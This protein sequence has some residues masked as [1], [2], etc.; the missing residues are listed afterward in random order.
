[1]QNIIL[2]VRLDT[3]FIVHFYFPQK[4]NCQNTR[5]GDGAEGVGG[6]GRGAPPQKKKKKKLPMY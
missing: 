2:K 4:Y 6:G 1:M 3:F 5:V